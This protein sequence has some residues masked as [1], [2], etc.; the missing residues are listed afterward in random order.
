MQKEIDYKDL[1]V[2]DVITYQ[3]GSDTIVTHRI[4]EINDK[5]KL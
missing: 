2:D 5:E 3:L 1:K 4:K